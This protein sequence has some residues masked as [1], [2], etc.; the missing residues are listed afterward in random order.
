MGIPSDIDP[1]KYRHK[2]HQQN[3]DYQP[4]RAALIYKGI[5][6][7]KHAYRATCA[8]YIDECM[9]A[10]RIIIHINR[11]EKRTHQPADEI[12][13]AKT[14][15][16]QISLQNRAK[17]IQHHHIECQMHQPAVHKHRAKDLPIKPPLK[18]QGIKPQKRVVFAW[19]D[20]KDDDIQGDERV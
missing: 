17:L 6:S 15:T 10:E 9:R 16:P 2:A 7:H 1:H 5:V 12:K 18:A 14:P 20:E 19:R 3:G 11:A 4:F 8:H 13:C